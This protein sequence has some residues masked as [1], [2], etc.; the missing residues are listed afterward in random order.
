MKNRSIFYSVIFVALVSFTT[1]GV[2]TLYFLKNDYEKKT[3]TMF[4]RYQIIRS[5]ILHHQRPMSNAEFDRYLRQF[6]MQIIFSISE[7]LSVL[8]NAV[9][10]KKDKR[11]LVT[12]TFLSAPQPFI[13]RKE[14]ELDISMIEYQ[15]RIYFYMRT[16]LGDTLIYD[17][18]L[19]PYV[20]SLGVFAFI[21]ILL[22]LLAT[23]I[24][25]IFKLYPLR[26]VSQTLSKFGA[27][28]LNVRLPFKGNDEVG[29]ISDAFNE[30]VS[31]I[32]H[33]IEGRTLFMRNVMHELKTPIAKGR[34]LSGMLDSEYERERFDRIFI[35]LQKLIDDFALLDQ[36]KSNVN[37]SLEETYNVRDII[38]E[39]IEIGFYEKENYTVKEK[40]TLQCKVDYNLFV[41]VCKNLIDNGIKYSIDSHIIIEIDKESISFKSKGENLKEPLEYY[42]EAFT[43]E[44]RKESFGLGL[45]IV[46]SILHRHK[47]KLE[48]SYIDGYNNFYIVCK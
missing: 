34:L 29:E 41:I 8:K 15:E 31:Q 48:H 43:G 30:A 23:F 38:D 32:K 17:E 42:S 7:K 16:P 40:K 37:I 6:D 18:T 1:I 10:L 22:V 3:E 27:G 13:A 19:N 33:L 24:F 12:Q 9:L 28:D 26:T 39:A 11:K 36:V 44:K 4:D 2:L 21:A 14:I 47:F 25:I 20:Y 45:Y 5:I 46:N 35:R